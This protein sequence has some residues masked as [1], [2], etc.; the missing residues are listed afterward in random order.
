MKI[1]QF[2]S[3]VVQSVKANEVTLY[4]GDKAL[5]LL[6]EEAFQESWDILYDS[7]PW[8]TVFQS[9]PF[10]TTWYQIYRPEFSPIIV[11]ST[12]GDKLTGLVTLTATH[13]SIKKKRGHIVGAGKYDA[14]YQVW[15]AEDK[16]N[17][18]F[19][20]AAI[21]KVLQAFPGLVIHFRY[22]KNHVPL[23]WIDEASWKNRC[24]LETYSCPLM[25]MKDP[26]LSKL[27]QKTTYRNCSNRLKRLGEVKF[28]HILSEEQLAANVNDFMIMYD[29]RQGAMFNRN[30]FLDDPLK[31]KL[32][33]A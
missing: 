25:E 8:A 15:L 31:E 2:S 28:E 24:L 20:K 23:Q 19:I 6:K 26:S 9:R 27:P 22:V 33:W 29:F 30:Q 4:T 7:C 21:S 5:A 1:E 17:N 12:Y 14:A 16:D 3:A 13:S 11:T 18:H 32:F 10:V